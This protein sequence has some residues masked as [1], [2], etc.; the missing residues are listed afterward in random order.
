M[1][2]LSE[3]TEKKE[4]KEKYKDNCKAFCVTR[5]HKKRCCFNFRLLFKVVVRFVLSF[6]IKAN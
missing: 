5:Q 3:N 6:V 2:S 4:N 1:V